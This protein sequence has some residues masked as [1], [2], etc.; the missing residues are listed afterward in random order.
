VRPDPTA[1]SAAGPPGAPR[2]TLILGGV[3][4]GKSDR[5]VALAEGAG[6]DRVLFVATAQA[7]DDDMARR[8]AAHRRERPASW[9]TLE[10]P[11]ALPS[12]LAHRLAAAEAAGAPYGAVVIDC[13]TLWV[14]NLLLALAPR[15]T[16]S[17]PSPPAC[18]SCWRCARPR[19]T[20]GA[21]AA[22]TV[23][24]GSW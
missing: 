2:L 9:D 22:A 11:L 10:S 21:P 6:R 24:G 14:S 5:A 15:T 13:L 4:S 19:A 20:G 17:R 23:R 12:D 3:R 16:R 7:F 1:G 18:A 8:I